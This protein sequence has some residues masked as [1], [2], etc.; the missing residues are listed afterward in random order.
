LRQVA[1]GPSNSEHEYSDFG[2]R[3]LKGFE[4]EEQIFEVLWETNAL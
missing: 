4:D 1:N 3:V 2:R